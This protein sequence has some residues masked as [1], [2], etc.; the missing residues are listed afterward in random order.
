MCVKN[1]SLSSSQRKEEKGRRSKSIKCS[2]DWVIERRLL[3]LTIPRPKPL[4]CFFFVFVTV[5]VVAFMAAFVCLCCFV[6]SREFERISTK[7]FT[8]DTREW[9]VVAIQL[10]G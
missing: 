2:C 3:L 6:L 1:I 8:Y 7:T 9:C 4:K 5:N 10:S